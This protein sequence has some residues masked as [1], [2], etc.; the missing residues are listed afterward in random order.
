[1]LCLPVRKPEIPL[2]LSIHK[3]PELSL[4][5]KT[6][7]WLFCF[8]MFSN[9][10]FLVSLISRPKRVD[11]EQNFLKSA[12]FPWTVLTSLQPTPKA[13][14][15]RRFPAASSIYQQTEL[16][17]FILLIAKQI[18]CRRS[19][20]ETNPKN[21]P[22]KQMAETLRRNNSQKQITRPPNHYNNSSWK[23]LGV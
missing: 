20:A 10:G 23:P 2:I 9:V 15:G 16:L 7:R 12:Q 21:V 8:C 17:C 4:K 6:A 13:G 22:Q 3:K 11:L 1:M 19:S 18:N 5:T 14:R